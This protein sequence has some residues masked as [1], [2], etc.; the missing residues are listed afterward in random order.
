MAFS[1]VYW[2]AL[3]GFAVLFFGLG[4]AAAAAAAQADKGSISLPIFLFTNAGL[5]CAAAVFV[6]KRRNPLEI[7]DVGVGEALI[8][9]GGASLYIQIAVRLC[10]ASASFGGTIGRCGHDLCHIARATHV[11][12]P[13][14]EERRGRGRRRG[15]R[16]RGPRGT[17]RTGSTSD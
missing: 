1:H 16:R 13:F 12:F 9:A 7:P 5:L 11:S 15:R 8:V 2:Q 4:T 6:Q 10:A 14:L 17:G 3:T